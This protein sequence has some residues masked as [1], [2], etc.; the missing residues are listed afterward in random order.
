MEERDAKILFNKSGGTASREGITN[1]VTIP[2]RWTKA[3]GIT[4]EDREVRLIFDEAKKI[5]KIEKR[6]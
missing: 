2:T 3:M 6:S 4:L 1:R 5:I